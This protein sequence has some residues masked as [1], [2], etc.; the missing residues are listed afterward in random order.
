[1][2]IEEEVT[3]MFKAEVLT[4][5]VVVVAVN[6]RVEFMTKVFEGAILLIVT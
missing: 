4:A 3:L 1:M 2:L 6:S 5:V